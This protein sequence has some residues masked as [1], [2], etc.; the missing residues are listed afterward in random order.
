MRAAGS[1]KLKVTGTGGCYVWSDSVIVTVN[2][3]PVPTITLVGDTL[4]SSS[5]TG[6]Q[7]FENGVRI[8]G[9]TTPK[10]SP[11]NIDVY[12]VQVTSGSCVSAMSYPYLYTAGTMGFK[13]KNEGTANALLYPNP[14][15]DAAKLQLSGFTSGVIV[16]ITDMTGRVVYQQD[17][18]TN[19]T[20]TL[21]LSKLAQGMYLVTIKDKTTIRT[22]R[23]IKA[24]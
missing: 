8:P 16:T 13:G 5:P 1:Y 9:A 12:T 3:V 11:D 21:P 17:K 22:I 18:L 24:K 4:I 14:A 10:Y 19:S 23:L 6:N 2:Q 7:W 20:Y 15:T